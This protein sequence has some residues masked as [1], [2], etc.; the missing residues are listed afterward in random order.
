MK[1]KK[2]RMKKYKGGFSKKL[3]GRVNLAIGGMPKAP[4]QED[5]RDSMIFAQEDERDIDDV[6][7]GTYNG[8]GGGTGG[9]GGGTGGAGQGGGNA[10]GTGGG[11]AGSGGGAVGQGDI[12]AA[13]IAGTANTGGGGG[14]GNSGTNAGNSGAGGSGIV[15]IRYLTEQ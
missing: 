15:I 14:S 13:G 2:K 4:V 7:R 9:Q 1:N 6:Y 11:G 8:Q 10:G 3:Q 5:P 12:V